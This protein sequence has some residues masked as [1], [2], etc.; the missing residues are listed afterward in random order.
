MTTC[1]WNTQLSF[2][3]KELDLNS[4]CYTRNISLDREQHGGSREQEGAEMLTK[5]SE[6]IDGHLWEVRIG[7]LI[8][9]YQAIESLTVSKYWFSSS[10]VALLEASLSK[11]G[12]LSEQLV[13][14]QDVL[15][16]SR[17]QVRSSYANT[18]VPDVVFLS[19]EP[20][21]RS[22]PFDVSTV[23]SL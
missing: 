6:I 14:F 1:V 23:R 13:D 11:V 7:A 3:E 19:S 10:V 2:A 12:I 9:L 17:V 18:F 20:R 8:V 4:S 15:H 16:I 5:D 21:C 22:S